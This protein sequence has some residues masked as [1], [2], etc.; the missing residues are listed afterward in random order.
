MKR[1]ALFLRI[2][3]RRFDSTAIPAPYRNDSRISWQ[4]AWQVA[5]AVHP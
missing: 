5:K 2:V 3:W 1:I 4:T